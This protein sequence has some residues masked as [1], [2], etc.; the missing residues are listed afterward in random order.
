MK[1]TEINKLFKAEPFAFIRLTDSAGNCV[2]S[3]NKVKG[4]TEEQEKEIAELLKSNLTPSGIYKLCYKT[5]VNGK[6]FAY[7]IE[8]NLK[9]GE[10]AEPQKNFLS[11]D[12]ALKYEREIMELKSA[13]NE[14]EKELSE[15]K[16]ELTAIDEEPEELAE[17]TPQNT[18]TI[19]LLKEVGLPLLDKAF[20]LWEQSVNKKSEPAAN[21]ETYFYMFAPVD[22][23][24][25]LI[26][27]VQA[28]PTI[29]NYHLLKIKQYR[30]EINL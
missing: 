8:K 13:L 17:A 22:D 24:R 18:E 4:K 15:L 12:D 9:P 20:N 5:T 30:P 19:T 10:L 16:E 6:E 7:D 21:P 3:W 1:H 23:L 26:E 27:S 28:N 25:A 14:R 2:V 29:L 11:Y